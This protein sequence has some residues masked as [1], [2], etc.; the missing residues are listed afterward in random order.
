M[1]IFFL[2]PFWKYKNI[3]Y[4]SSLDNDN[5]LS[6]GVHFIRISYHLIIRYD[7]TADYAWLNVFQTNELELYPN[8]LQTNQLELYPQ[9][10]QWIRVLWPKAYLEP[11]QTSTTK[12]LFLKIVNV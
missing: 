2:R 11:M 6:L 5:L 12:K 8:V 1:L 9:W 10:A 4:V 7:I 3:Q